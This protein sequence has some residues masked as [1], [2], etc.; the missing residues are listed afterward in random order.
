MQGEGCRAGRCDQPQTGG[1]Q[2]AGKQPLQDRQGMRQDVGGDAGIGF[3]RLAFCPGGK[4]RKLDQHRRAKALAAAQNGLDACLKGILMHWTEPD[5]RRLGNVQ[6]VPRLGQIGGERLFGEGM[7]PLRRRQPQQAA[8]GGGGGAQM[9]KVGRGRGQHRLQIRIGRRRDP[10]GA[11][12]VGIRRRHNQRPGPSRR[13]GMPAA[14][15]SGPGD[16]HARRVA[17]RP[18]HAEAGLR[19][20]IR[21]RI[22]AVRGAM[23]QAVT[24]VI[25]GA[26]IGAIIGR[27][28]LTLPLYGLSDQR[29]TSAR[30]PIQISRLPRLQTAAWRDFCN[31]KMFKSAPSQP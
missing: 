4:E 31:L 1:G 15:Q 20:G 23:A 3:G 26:I 8:M 22:A 21:A 30:L 17:N 16:H 6:Q 12:H 7:H 29:S 25:P 24:Q 14:H 5:S 13:M 11:G 27:S 19:G 28:D 9:Q 10:G 2:R 18:R